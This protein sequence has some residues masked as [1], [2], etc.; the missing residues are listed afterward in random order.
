VIEASITGLG[1]Q[2]NRCLAEVAPDQ[3]DGA[4]AANASEGER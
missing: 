3:G 1:A 2:R 4:L